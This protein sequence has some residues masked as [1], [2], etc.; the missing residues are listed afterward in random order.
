MK[1]FPTSRPALLRVGLVF[2]LP[3]IVSWFVMIRMPGRSFHGASPPL[4]NAELALRDE[5]RSDVQKLAGEIGER[6]LQ[7]YEHLVAAAEFIEQSFVK[8]GL[9]PR[10]DGY[11]VA[12]KLCENLE[13]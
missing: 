8:A 11:D 9:K 5:L 3:A 13:V 7:R 10:R 6:N 1:L 2:V 4:T 12:G